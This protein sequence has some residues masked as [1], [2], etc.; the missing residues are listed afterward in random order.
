MNSVFGSGCVFN[1]DV[2]ER[3]GNIGIHDPN[4][5]GSQCCRSIAMKSPKI[6]RDLRSWS[7]FFYLNYCMQTK[8]LYCL[9]TCT[10]VDPQYA[11]GGTQGH[12]Q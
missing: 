5:F 3:L 10:T 7:V 6:V 2:R 4:Y 8:L 1:Q 9:L 11:P 12:N